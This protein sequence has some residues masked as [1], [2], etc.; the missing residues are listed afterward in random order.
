MPKEIDRRFQTAGV[1]LKE[2]YAQ[3]NKPRF[4]VFGASIPEPASGSRQP[5][6]DRL[7]VSI[8]EDAIFRAADKT[9][10]AIEIPTGTPLSS[11]SEEAS[12]FTL[13]DHWNST[14]WCLPLYQPDIHLPSSFLQ[15]KTLREAW[16]SDTVRELFVDRGWMTEREASV[17]LKSC[18]DTLNE[19]M[20]LID[21]NVMNARIAKWKRHI[22][23]SPIPSIIQDATG[24]A[25]YCNA[26]FR[27]ITN[28]P[29]DINE[30]SVLDLFDYPSSSIRMLSWFHFAP[31]SRSVSSSFLRLWSPT[32]DFKPVQR[33]GQSY[34]EGVSW[35]ERD[36]TPEQ[37]PYCTCTFFMP[38]PS[39]VNFTP[40]QMRDVMD[41]PTNIRN[42][43][44][45]AHVDHGK[46]TLTDS[47]I[48]AA[49]IIS[50]DAAGTMRLTDTREDEIERG[51]TIKSTG[52][53]L[54][55]DVPQEITIPHDSRGREFVLNLIDSPGH[56]DFSSEVTAAL[57]VTDGA[58][59][60]VDMVEGVSVQTETVLRQALSENV[61]PVVVINK[62]D[63]GFL[64]LDKDPEDM[65]RD[66][67]RVIEDANVIIGTYINDIMGDVTV[68]AERG[69]VAFA[70]GLQGWAFTLDTFARMYATRLGKSANK[71][72][73]HLW[74]DHFYDA[75]RKKW[76]TE[77]ISPE[78][79]TLERGF[80]KFILHPIREV[81]R[82]CMSSDRQRLEAI[83][84]N[85]R[86]HLNEEEKNLEPKKLLRTV[87]RR[88][89]PADNALLEMSVRHLPSPARA[90][91]Y[92]CSQL[93]TGPS[94]DVTAEAI[95]RCDPNGPLVMYVSKMVPTNDGGRFYAFGRVFSGTV[96]T[97][98]PV[99]ILDPHHVLGQSRPNIKTVQRVVV[100][101]GRKMEAMATIPCGNTCALLGV[102]QHIVKTATLTTD[103]TSHPIA[104]MKFSV[105]P[106]VEMAVEPKH[107]TDL[108]KLV[109]GIRRMVSGDSLIQSRV[110][111]SG[112][113]IVAGAGELH[114]EICLKDLVGYMGGADIIVSPPIVT[115]REGISGTSQLCR[116][117]STNKHNRF[118]AVAEPLDPRIL[119]G[120]E[121]GGI[122]LDD[123]HKLADD[124]GWSNSEIK[125]LWTFGPTS[126]PSCTLSD[127]TTGAEYL[128]EIKSSVVAGF[129]EATRHGILCGESVRGAHYRILDVSIHSSSAQRGIGQ[130]LPATRRL[131]QAAQLSAGPRLVEP[132]YAVDIICPTS[133]MGG[134][135]GVL[136]RRRGKILEEKEREGT[137]LREIKSYM[138]VSEG[139]GFVAELA[140]ATGGKAFPTCIFDHWEMM[141]EDPTREGEAMDIVKSIRKRK[142]YKAELPVLADLVDMMRKK[143]DVDF[144]SCHCAV[145]T[146]SNEHHTHIMS[147]YK[148][149]A[150]NAESGSMGQKLLA[151]GSTISM[152]LWV[153]NAHSEHQPQVERDYE[154]V[155]YVL[156]GSAE[157]HLGSEV[158]ELRQGDSW[159]V[160]RHTKHTYKIT[161]D[162]KAV[163]ATHPIA[164]EKGRDAAP[165]QN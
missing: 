92:R 43:T 103:D 31:A 160:P 61:V 71:I 97:G 9:A 51:I 30:V 110:D 69:T 121:E 122:R 60:V 11:Y 93:Y 158:I 123:P 115:Y 45:I 107:P 3:T 150:S 34:T 82:A 27:K 99:R 48:A 17:Y 19:R 58:L 147:Q 50:A 90:Q 141:E 8:I 52:I 119:K 86:V 84:T 36:M 137:P 127:S 133:A 37:F 144:N 153:E 33:H 95:K 112:V 100:A 124:F 140:K 28:L 94:D 47:L 66:F 39:A 57:R 81:F 18:V 83:L 131:F 165:Q 67:V 21:V 59:V 128:R 68:Y 79:K 161:S 78:G 77:P 56:V 155:G 14:P 13:Q 64:E 102:D 4:W 89:L 44:V 88:W 55:F 65:Y 32:S 136:N 74:G 40:E 29:H 10:E 63:R 25:V 152:R 1:I 132:M 70:C 87:M 154:T 46:S 38:S 142:G 76:T 139:F 156:S 24:H 135:Y 98:T 62:L 53:S 2:W 143:Y 7:T 148:V 12:V 91:S 5:I 114:L 16:N 96:T 111:E 42:L 23:I 85:T 117:K 20:R 157:L 75:E 73:D 6:T 149:A 104:T 145:V 26:A 72:V 80:C 120:I 35:M 105:S 109:E 159:V 15:P 134:V 22:D 162:F 146:L 130:V 164:E 113:H 151:R 125:R 41:R 49:G 106:V 118:T 108:P 101:M 54:Y 129:E 163:E 138:P 116:T 126:A